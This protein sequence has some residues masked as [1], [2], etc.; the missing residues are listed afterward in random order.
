MSSFDLFSD[1]VTALVFIETS[2]IP[3]FLAYAMNS[4]SLGLRR[5]SPLQFN[6]IEGTPRLTASLMRS[7]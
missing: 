2:N 6:L 4:L 1:N 5:G 3:F 7:L